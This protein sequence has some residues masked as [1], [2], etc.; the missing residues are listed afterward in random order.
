MLPWHCLPEPHGVLQR[1]EK[2]QDCKGER[3]REGGEREGGR[4]VLKRSNTLYMYRQIYMYIINLPILT[5]QIIA[6]G[7]IT[8]TIQIYTCKPLM[9]GFPILSAAS[10]KHGLS[11]SVLSPNKSYMNSL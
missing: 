10:L 7:I 9:Y 4:M 8:I 2:E 6:Y 11:W 1:I 3:G 5:Y